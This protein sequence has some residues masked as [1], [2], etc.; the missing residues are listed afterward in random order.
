M[1]LV[2]YSLRRSS[3][4]SLYS[5]CV[6]PCFYPSAK[7]KCF[8]LSAQRKYFHPSAKSN[9]GFV[10]NRLPD[11]TLTIGV[12]LMVFSGLNCA[13]CGRSSAVIVVVVRVDNM[14]IHKT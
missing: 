13:Q 8:H 12:S 14:E 7:R 5:A 11:S 4:P 1:P 6:E 2:Q 9:P 3:A 10:G